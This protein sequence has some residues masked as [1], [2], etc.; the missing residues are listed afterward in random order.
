MHVLAA[1][2]EVKQTAL[3]LPHSAEQD[4]RSFCPCAELPATGQCLKLNKSLSKAILLTACLQR[5]AQV[6]L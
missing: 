6:S 2:T 3:G 1:A 4:G 5:L